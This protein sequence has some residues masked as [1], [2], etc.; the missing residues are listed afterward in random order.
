MKIEMVA[1]LRKILNFLAFFK[2]QECGRGLK[3]S[4]KP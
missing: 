4:Y 1:L 2:M 3:I